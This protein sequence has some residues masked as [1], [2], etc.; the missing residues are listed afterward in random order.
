MVL[1]APWSTY[2][3]SHTSLGGLFIIFSKTISFVC[4]IMTSLP[5]DMLP[6]NKNGS[7]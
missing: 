5:P 3:R 4:V 6:F 2:A 1:E 7:I